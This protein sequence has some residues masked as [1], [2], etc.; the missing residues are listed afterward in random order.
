M[1][2][3][4][5]PRL[6]RVPGLALDDPL[7]KAGIPGALVIDLT[8]IERV[9][10]DLVEVAPAEGPA[11]PHVLGEVLVEFAHE[12]EAIGLGL[13]GRDGAEL[14]VQPE[15]G[16]DDLGLALDDLKRAVLLAV[17]ERDVAA[18]PHALLLRG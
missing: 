8:D 2:V 13:Q 7:V 14:E 4:F 11:T 5:Q 15:Q 3:R 9:R 18:H 10:Q 17:A 16:A 6:N 1:T 12:A